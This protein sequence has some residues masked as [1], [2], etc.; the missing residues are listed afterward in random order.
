MLRIYAFRVRARSRRVSNTMSE[1]DQ[2]VK[3][4]KNL[5]AT[6]Q[7]AKIR[8]GDQV[9]YVLDSGPGKG[10][11]RMA[12]VVRKVLPSDQVIN[13]IVLT[14]GMNDFLQAA[15]GVLWLPSVPY[16]AENAEGSWHWPEP[17]GTQRPYRT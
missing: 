16:S 4:R 9:E 17:T 14:D 2:L 11:S 5:N 8:M 12:F 10:Q 6:V 1:Q 3:R 13:L 7:A 15:Q